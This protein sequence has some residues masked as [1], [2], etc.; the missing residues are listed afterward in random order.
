[1]HHLVGI[2]PAGEGQYAV[3]ELHS[4]IVGAGMHDDSFFANIFKTLAIQAIA[5]D[6]FVVRDRHV[7]KTFALNPQENDR[8]GFGQDGIEVALEAYARLLEL[9]GS[10]TFGADEQYVSAD[11]M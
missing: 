7:G 1:M 2:T 5:F 11:A 10:E 6:V 8:V 3:V 9:A 4:A